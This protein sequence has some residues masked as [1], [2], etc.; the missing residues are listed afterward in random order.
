MLQKELDNTNKDKWF[1]GWSYG[2]AWGATLFLVAAVGLLFYDRNT[3]E[4]FYKEKLCLNEEEEAT[5]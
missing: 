4:I 3:E 1:F 2:L 5:A